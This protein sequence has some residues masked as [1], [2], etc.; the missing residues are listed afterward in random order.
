MGTFLH[1]L[2]HSKLKNEQDAIGEIGTAPPVPAAISFNAWIADYYVRFISETVP[3]GWSLECEVALAY[4]FADGRFNLSGHIDDCAMS[5]DGTEAIIFDL[6]TG[7]DPVDP[8]DSNNQI[9]GYCALLLKAYPSLTSIRSYI[10]Q[11]LVDEDEG[12]Q[13]ISGPAVLDGAVLANAIPYLER[14]ILKALANADEVNSGVKQ[15]KW[16]RCAPQ[17]PAILATRELMKMKLTADAVKGI[18][19]TPDDAVLADWVVAT[20]ILSRP[21]DDAEKLAKVRIAEAG[22]ITSTEGVVITAQT[23]PGSYK[24]PRPA[25]TLAA[26]RRHLPSDDKL[27]LALSFSVSKARDAIAE[28]KGIPKESRLGESGQSIVDSEIKPL[29]EQGTRVTLQF[30]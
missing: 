13:R 19:K 2:A 8:A 27:A 5:P 1:W 30:Q 6:K 17:C 28:A 4:E 29:A 11:P 22:S 15:C 3:P 24:W 26:L 12:Y 25:E 9:L 20:K 18:K 14:E 23:G 21:M 16:C 7:R 10:V